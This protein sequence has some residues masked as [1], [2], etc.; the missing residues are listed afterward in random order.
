M[1]LSI[2]IKR[3]EKVS[4][5]L[6]PDVYLFPV[7]FPVQS[8]PVVQGGGGGGGGGELPTAVAPYPVDVN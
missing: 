2:F 7:L 6:F 3:Q 4:H 5:F 1:F 8:G